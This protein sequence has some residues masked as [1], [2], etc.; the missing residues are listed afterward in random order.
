MDL[1]QGRRSQD[2]RHRSVAGSSNAGP[3]GSR[4]R[5]IRGERRSGTERRHEYVEKRRRER[6]PVK[7]GSVAEFKR[8][9]LFNIGKAR[10]AGRARIVEISSGGL[11]IQYAGYRMWPLDFRRL[12]IVVDEDQLVIEDLPITVVT[13][14]KV[15]HTP[16]GVPVRRCGL[17]FDTLSKAAIAGIT[18]FIKHYTI[19]SRLRPAL[20]EAAA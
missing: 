8:P 7:Q 15:D 20:S 14:Y 5:R 13:D 18:H 10:I 3:H 4:D 6:A 2:R 19:E 9:R 11:T 1:T 16:D 12:T 17:K